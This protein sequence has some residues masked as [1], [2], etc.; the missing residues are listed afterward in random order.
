MKP[1]WTQ[2]ICLGES[3]FVPTSLLEPDNFL[4]EDSAQ[5]N[6]LSSVPYHVSTVWGTAFLLTLIFSL[7]LMMLLGENSGN[8]VLCE[9]ACPAAAVRKY[10]YR[11]PLQGFVQHLGGNWHA[12]SSSVLCRV[13]PMGVLRALQSMSHGNVESFAEYVPPEC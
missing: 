4:K 13:R 1:L 12:M 6:I 10:R 2:L 5:P 9:L 11:L 7:C 8:S 3:T